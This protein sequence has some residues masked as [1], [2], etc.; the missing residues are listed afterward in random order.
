MLYYKCPTCKTILANREPIYEKEMD[1]ICKD[2][3]I[4]DKDKAK[5]DLINSLELQRPCCRMRLM[6]YVDLIHII[7]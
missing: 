1:R 5:K 7:K 3:S 4:K 6:G 2:N